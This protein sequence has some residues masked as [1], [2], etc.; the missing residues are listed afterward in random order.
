[1][2]LTDEQLRAARK[3]EP[4]PN[5]TQEAATKPQCNFIANLIEDR[6]VPPLWLV[7]IKN[8]IE[9]EGGLKKG[10]ASEIIGALRGLPF[11]NKSEFQ[12]QKQDR[13]KA[14]H[15]RDIPPGRYCVQTGEDSND[16]G[17]FRV[18]ERTAQNDS[19]KKYKIMLRIAGPQEHFIRGEEAA[20]IVKLIVRAG[21]GE[22]A[23]RYGHEVGRC[24]ICHTRITNRVSRELGIGPV[25]GGRVY[26]DWDNRVNT[27]RNSL[28]ERGL[29]PD[30]NV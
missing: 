26:D 2:P 29:D 14:P 7:R 10:K 24:S 1:M 4:L 15:I 19:S 11:K 25:C 20:K 12:G 28:R 21:V 6:E 3:A 27:A 18:K 22:A 5:W 23:T 8:Y 30:E 9:E 16:L 13:S 17:F